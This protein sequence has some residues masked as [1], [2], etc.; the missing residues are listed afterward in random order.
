MTTTPAPVNFTFVPGATFVGNVTLTDSNGDA[1]DLTSHTALMHIRREPTDADPLFILSTAN[2][3]IV[4]GG[5]LG[6]IALNIDAA[7]TD[8]IDVDEDG[9]TW[10]YDILLTNTVPATDIVEQK[11]RGYVFATYP[12]TRSA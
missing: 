9:E 3:R 10:W 12:I 4:L 11:L 2:T 7:D 5:A 1:V 6:T 8:V